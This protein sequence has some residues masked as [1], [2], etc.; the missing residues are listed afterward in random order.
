MSRT[1]Y[2]A[3]GFLLHACFPRKSVVLLTS[4]MRSGSTLLKALLARAPDVSHLPEID[5]RSDL[6]SP[7]LLYGR[8]YFRCRERIVLLKKPQ[9]FEET[10][11]MGPVPDVKIIVLVRDA[12]DV[13]KSLER[14]LEVP[15]VMAMM[16]RSGRRRRFI[17]L[18]QRGLVDYWCDANEA[19]LALAEK[20]EAILV[21]YEDLVADPENVTGEVFAFL[22]SEQQQG[23]DSYG[24]GD[25]V[26]W[27]W[28]QDDGGDKIR[29]LKTIRPSGPRDRSDSDLVALLALSE[30]VAGLRG[31]LGYAEPAG[32]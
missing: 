18:D 4:S 20:R 19:L 8:S 2:T 14:M 29:S 31:R 17:G 28:G 16:E 22:G 27:Q 5:F 1:I 25:A 32:S 23:V 9:W 6:R 13:V 11:T 10:W 12:Y 15:E 7:H 21:R 30:R 3:L 24:D 26:S